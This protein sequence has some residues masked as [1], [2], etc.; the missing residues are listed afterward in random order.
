LVRLPPKPRCH[1]SLRRRCSAAIGHSAALLSAAA[2]DIAAGIAGG[3]GEEGLLGQAHPA[4]LQLI[5]L[6]ALAG[7][8]AG[9]SRARRHLNKRVSLRRIVINLG[10]CG[11]YIRQTLCAE[12]TGKLVARFIQLFFCLAGVRIYDKYSHYSSLVSVFHKGF[13]YYKSQC[14]GSVTF[15]ASRLRIRI[16]TSTSKDIKKNLHF[17]S[18]VIMLMFFL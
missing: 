11:Q 13:S 3:G 9:S 8:L 16:L 12:N 4:I 10:V 7:R 5:H 2:G 18:F 1:W 6:Q 14:S 15:L 17:Y